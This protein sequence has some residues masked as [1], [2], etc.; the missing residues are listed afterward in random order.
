MSMN[1]CN[2]SYFYDIFIYQMTIAQI[3]DIPQR[4]TCFP[5]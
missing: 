3:I 2:V 4:H 5:L 1:M